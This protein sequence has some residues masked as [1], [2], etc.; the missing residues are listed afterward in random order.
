MR[1]HIGWKI[2]ENYN[3]SSYSKLWLLQ[4]REEGGG[5]GGGGGEEEEEEDEEE[6]KEMERVT[7]RKVEYW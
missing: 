4:Y 2:Q 5:G 6:K 1:R 7:E 3:S